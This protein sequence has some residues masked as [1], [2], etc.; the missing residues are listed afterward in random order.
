MYL[1]WHVTIGEGEIACHLPLNRWGWHAGSHS[2]RWFG[3]EFAQPT[4]DDPITDLQVQTFCWWWRNVVRKRWP[5]VPDHFLGHS[6]VRQGINAGKTDPYTV[7]SPEMD[8]LR[9]RI[10]SLVNG[11]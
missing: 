5:G 7:G 6:E 2:R 1:A 10:L 4:G 3:A 9:R 11:G 8:N